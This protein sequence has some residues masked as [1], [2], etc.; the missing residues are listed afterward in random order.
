MGAEEA[1]MSKILVTGAGGFLG[2]EIVKKLLALGHEVVGLQRSQYQKLE[3]LG[4]T[5]VTGSL[6]DLAAVKKAADGCDAIFHV[7]AKAGVWGSYDSYY[8]TNVVGTENVITACRELGIKKLIYTSSPSVTFEG[9]DEIGVDESVGYAKRYLTAYPET[10]AIA[11]K[12]ILC[13]NGQDL[14]TVALRPHLIWG[15]NDTNL[16]PRVVGRFRAGKLKIIGDGKNL[17]DHTY[18]TNAADAHIQAYDELCGEGK[19]GGKAYFISNG[20]PV[21]MGVMLNRILEAAGEGPVVKNIPA[22]LAYIAGVGFEFAYRV[23]GRKDEPIMTRFVAKQ[24]STAHYYDLAASRRD[25]GYNPIV[26]LDQG[27]AI[28]ANNLRK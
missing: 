26:S 5:Q 18:V 12:K 2:F 14:R 20:E 25:F 8:Q 24:L 4:V 19:C 28:L 3:D 7:A 11:E 13:E 27:M 23:L 1:Q 17:V 10:K 22:W 15:P 9:V 6:T 21:E 16:V